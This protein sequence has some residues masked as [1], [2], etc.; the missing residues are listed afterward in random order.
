MERLEQGWGEFRLFAALF[1]NDDKKN[2][3]RFE[4]L[5]LTSLGTWT[6]DDVVALVVALVAVVVVAAAALVAVV[7]AVVASK[8]ISAAWTASQNILRQVTLF[9]SQE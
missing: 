7:V 3:C 8:S 2:R 1:E 5:H 9:S 4:S 6:F